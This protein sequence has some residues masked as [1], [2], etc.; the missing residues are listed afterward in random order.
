MIMI[1]VIIKPFYIYRY[2]RRE[3]PQGHVPDGHR[4][5]Q[6]DPFDPA[7]EA[8]LEGEGQDRLL[9]L[10]GREGLQLSGGRGK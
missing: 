3:A 5:Q 2:Y 8:L 1:I 10:R 6:E 7:V 4:R 9:H